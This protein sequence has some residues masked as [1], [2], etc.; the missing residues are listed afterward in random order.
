MSRYL[1]LFDMD[2]TLLDVNT[3]ALYVRWRRRH[4][5]STNGDVL[6][7]A[8]WLL[9][10]KFGLLD[11]PR[12][13]ERVMLQFKGDREEALRLDCEHWYRE[14][15]RPHIVSQGCLVIEQ[16]RAAG[17]VIAV[18]TSSTQ[19]AAAPLAAELGIAHLICTELDV[20]GQGHFTG[21]IKHPMCFGEGKVQRAQQWAQT[22][23]LDIRQAYFYTDSVTDAPLL[24]LVA[25]PVAVNPDPRLRSLAQSNGWRIERW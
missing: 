3:A 13:A 22:V 25:H 15:V 14:V 19:Y 24:A 20:D 12:I 23:G 8:Y 11:A 7:V 10:Y 17:A 5:L 4:G 1:A 6:R 18:V 2:G 9:K 16:H 21:H